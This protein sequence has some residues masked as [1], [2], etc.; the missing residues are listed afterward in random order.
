[1]EVTKKV[2]SRVR[3]IS[4][5]MMIIR[6]A[7]LQELLLE[8][9][10]Q[11]PLLFYSL[12]VNHSVQTNVARKR[13]FPF[14]SIP[15]I[16]RPNRWLIRVELQLRIQSKT[17]AKIQTKKLIA[18]ELSRIW[19]WLPVS[20]DYSRSMLPISRTTVLEIDRLRIR[21]K[22]HFSPQSMSHKKPITPHKS[23]K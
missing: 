20:T 6:P 2:K 23:E 15:M 11:Q 4:L 17:I 21:K 18:L 14:Q 19:S 1:M 5:A 7:L 9:L 8:S 16:A 22:N 10:L 13:M 3:I 12:C